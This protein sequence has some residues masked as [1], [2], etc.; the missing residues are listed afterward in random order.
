MVLRGER[1]VRAH[2]EFHVR[3]CRYMFRRLLR[4]VRGGGWWMGS[5]GGMSM[6]VAFFSDLVFFCLGGVVGYDGDLGSVEILDV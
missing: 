5:W 2:W 4:A 3:H 1:D 6:Y